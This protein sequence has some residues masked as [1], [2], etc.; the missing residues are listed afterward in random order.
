M[1]SAGGNSAISIS[2]SNNVMDDNCT[3]YITT[4]GGGGFI[5][6]VVRMVTVSGSQTWYLTAINGAAVTATNGVFD[7]IRIG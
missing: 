1:I 2:S 3:T 5:L 7:S 4:P 6:N